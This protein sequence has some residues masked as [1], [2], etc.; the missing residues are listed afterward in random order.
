MSMSFSRG[1]LNTCALE[2]PSV[3]VR[4]GVR[5]TVPELQAPVD[6]SDAPVDS[7]GPVDPVEPVSSPGGSTPPQVGIPTKRGES[8]A[9]VTSVIGPGAAAVDAQHATVPSA[10]ARQA[11]ELPAQTDTAFCPVTAPFP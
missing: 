8:S 9:K 6:E 1:E 11:S 7:A 2:A 5:S 3:R 4:E 10:R